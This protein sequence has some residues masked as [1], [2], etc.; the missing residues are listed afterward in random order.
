MLKRIQLIFYLIFLFTFI[1]LITFFYFSENNKI[2][3]N[4]NRSYYSIKLKSDI[5]HIPLL[6]NDT[7]DII[8]YNVKIENTKKKKLYKFFDL[9]KN[10]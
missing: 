1:I 2:T 7:T 8:D 6:E 9:L 3:I 4:K 5:A 10:N